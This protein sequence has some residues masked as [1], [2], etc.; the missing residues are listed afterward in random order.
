MFYKLGIKKQKTNKQTR[1]L[2]ALYF[3]KKGKVTSYGMSSHVMFR[4]IA[5]CNLSPSRRKWSL[6][7][8]QVRDRTREPICHKSRISED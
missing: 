8:K 1:V 4:Y 3:F 7:G 2:E 6:L 5:T